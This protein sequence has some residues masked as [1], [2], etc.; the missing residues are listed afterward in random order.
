[1]SS[2]NIIS[3]QYTNLHFL[4]GKCDSIAFHRILSLIRVIGC[5]TIV[6]DKYEIPLNN[7]N[8]YGN[9]FKIIERICHKVYFYKTNFQT[10]N[11][12]TKLNT[13]DLVGYCILYNDNFLYK[14]NKYMVSY[15]FEGI[16][17][18]TIDRNAY[19]INALSIKVNY[20]GAKFSIEG[21]N[22]CQQNRIT[23][24]SAHTA[25]MMALNVYFPEINTELINKT[26]NIDNVNRLGNEGLTLNEICNAIEGLTE[27]K[28]L[29]LA[30]TYFPSPQ[31]FL[32][33]IY[34][35]LDNKLPV[36]LFF[37]TV[38][39]GHALPLIGFSYNI[40]NWWPRAVK[41]YFAW[42]S[43][44]SYTSIFSYCDNFVVQDDNLGPYFLL[45]VS[46]LKDINESEPFNFSEIPFNLEEINR[47]KSTK[48]SL[49]SA[50][51]VHPNK[52]KEIGRIELVEKMSFIFL[53][54]Y[55][56]KKDEDNTING[57]E[58]STNLVRKY[59]SSGTLIFRTLI[60]SKK[61][62]LKSIK[63][64][65]WLPPEVEEF[66]DNAPD[67]LFIIEVTTSDI[68]CCNK[69]KIGDIVI[70]PTISSETMD[71]S[72]VLIKLPGEVA[73]F[74]GLSFIE[75]RLKDDNAVYPVIIPN[76]PFIEG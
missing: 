73:L 23:N 54:R 19:M 55:L 40:Q 20:Q 29:T 31:S 41:S 64:N 48:G 50:I 8:D 30:P 72:A 63:N 60:L 33:S 6:I 47:S 46:S 32:K 38:G 70:D 34:H 39:G 67:I 44:F 36:I 14:D 5:E 24:S 10:E 28:T 42:H 18:P 12:I 71:N 69:G 51:I 37:T 3:S 76:N 35:A 75:I 56:I 74:D 11:D 16:I 43:E 15:V 65:G 17:K 61:Q 27:H 66:L 7:I 45:P 4:F 62:Y 26:L 21:N 59:L 1:M 58:K 53:K 2:I 52:L 25:I 22:F 68:F 13:D 57:E 9:S 49:L